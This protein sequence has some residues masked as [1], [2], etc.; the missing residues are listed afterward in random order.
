MNKAKRHTF[1]MGPFRRY[2]VFKNQAAGRNISMKFQYESLPL[3]KL[4]FFLRKIGHLFK[5]KFIFQHLISG[6]FADP[7]NCSTGCVVQGIMIC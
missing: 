2:C 4:P 5:G 1:Y 3:I 6:A 7:Y